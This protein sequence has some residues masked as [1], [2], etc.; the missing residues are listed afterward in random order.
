MEETRL[1]ATL[2]EVDIVDADWDVV[3]PGAFDE[4]IAAK[5]KLNMLLMHFRVGI[6]G[7]WSNLRMEGTLLRA[8]GVLYTGDDGYEMAR[9]ARKLVMTEQLKG[10]SIGFRPTVWQSVRTE[11]RPYG[12]DIYKLDLIEASLVD[13]PANSSAE[14]TDLKRSGEKREGGEGTVTDIVLRKLF[15]G[16]IEIEIAPDPIFGEIEAAKR[17]LDMANSL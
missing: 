7:Q 8:D 16:Q 2:S 15:V 5:Q 11:E 9:Q 4:A 3:M 17:L 6:I 14:V 12:W 1:K 10:V 13:R